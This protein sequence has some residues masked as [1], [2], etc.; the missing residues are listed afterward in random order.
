MYIYI[1]HLKLL[2][3][4]IPL[5]HQFAY[6]HSP[7]QSCCYTIQYGY[8]YILYIYVYIIYILYSNMVI[9]LMWVKQCHKPTI[10]EWC[11]HIIAIHIL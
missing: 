6:D 7:N 9:I 3:V 4:N 11:K 2:P 1:H 5:S 8:I 10:W